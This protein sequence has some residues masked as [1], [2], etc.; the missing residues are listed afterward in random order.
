VLN[1]AFKQLRLVEV[2]I[3]VRGR[4]EFGES[5]VA[6]SLLRYAWRTLQIIF[7][8]YRDYHPLRFF[9]G[10]ALALLL[11]ATL[12]GGFLLVHWLAT[13]QL[14]PHKWAGFAAAGLAVVAVLALHMGVI[15]DMLNRHRVYLEELL[16][17]QRSGAGRDADPE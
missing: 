8:S 2:P 7:R 10:I 16:Y 4:R 3:R 12:L 5:R 15:G 1:L 9:G 14:S 6:R 17:R 11:P 13:G